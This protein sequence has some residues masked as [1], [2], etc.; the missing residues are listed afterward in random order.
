MP[1]PEEL[2]ATAAA[3]AAAK[4]GDGK[5]T[6]ALSSVQEKPETWIP[7]KYHVRKDGKKDGELDV[8]A[9]M[10]AV[11][12]GY[13]DLSKRMVDVGL[14][15]ED[16]DKYEIGGDGIPK[17]FDIAEFRKDQG[18]QDFLKGAHSL[19]LTNKQVNYVIGK[20]LAIAPELAGAAVELSTEECVAQLAL[21]WKSEAEMVS[22]IRGSRTAASK[23]AEAVGMTFDDVEAEFGNNPIFIRLMAGLAKQMGEDQPPNDQAGGGDVAADFDAQTRELRE[24]L[25]KL[26]EYAKEREAIHAKLNELYEKRYGK[27]GRAPLFV[28]QGKA[29]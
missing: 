19:G 21:T 17:E 24:K 13:G 26:P 22:N 23:L 16:A 4:G 1:T 5:D 27:G 18:M 3:E 20:Y 8:E 25:E 28:R 15:P 12:K 11:A 6:S 10:K 14:P 9:S 2:A 29:A 7:E